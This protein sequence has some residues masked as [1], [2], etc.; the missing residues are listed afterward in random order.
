MAQS[1][2]LVIEW[3]EDARDEVKMHIPEADETASDSRRFVK[4]LP[5]RSWPLWLK[6]KFTSYSAETLPTP[7]LLAT[8]QSICLASEPHDV[9][10]YGGRVEQ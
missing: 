9:A 2:S 3:V 5:R 1:F 4:E 6:H 10:L 7:S 8:G